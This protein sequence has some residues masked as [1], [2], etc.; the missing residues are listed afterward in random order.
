MTIEENPEGIEWVFYT[1][2]FLIRS[3]H[4]KRKKTKK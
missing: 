2:F 3:Y 4:M 1:L